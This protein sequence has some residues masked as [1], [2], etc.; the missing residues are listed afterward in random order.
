MLH[1]RIKVS[2]SD[3]VAVAKAYLLVQP[4]LSFET[5]TVED[6]NA[7]EARLDA[8]LQAS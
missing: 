7:E 5:I 2:A 8:A 3:G 1:K 6:T 4:D